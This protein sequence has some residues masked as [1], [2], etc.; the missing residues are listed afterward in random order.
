MSKKL[1]FIIWTVIAIAV[2]ALLG[3]CIYNYVEMNSKG[4]VHPHVSIEFEN[5]GTVEFELYPEYAPNTVANFIKLAQ[6]GYYN[7]KVMYG[8]DTM[9][10]YFG[11]DENGE[12]VEP[13]TET[14]EYPEASPY[15]YSIDGEFIA[16]GFAKNTLRHEKGV[17][18]LIRSNYT[19]YFSDLYDE[20]YNSGSSQIGIMMSD[21]SS[22]LNGVYAAFGR[23][24]NGLDILEKIYNE[25]EVVEETEEDVT[26]EDVEDVD[27]EVDEETDTESEEEED[28]GGIK[29][30][31]EYPKVTAVTVDTYGIDYGM[32][33]IH[34]AFDY[35]EYLNNYLQSYSA[36][37]Q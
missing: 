6:S 31:A 24:V 5:Y 16:N 22:N 21:Q 36:N 13:T 37:Y 15:N 33:E 17:V 32:P 34:K 2:V 25:L 27:E 23:V 30:F 7:D 35:T 3:L 12:V 20:S 28:K 26:E 10:L 4:N 11:R 8:K 9:C 18:S 29:K 19:E 1:Q 14:I